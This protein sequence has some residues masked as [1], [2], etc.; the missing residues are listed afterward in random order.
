M[1]RCAG[2]MAI[3]RNKRHAYRIL[4]GEPESIEPNER[5]RRNWDDNIKIDLKEIG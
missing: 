3:V 5:C 4:L 2:H 1:V